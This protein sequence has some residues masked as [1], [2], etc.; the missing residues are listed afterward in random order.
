MKT[1]NKMKFL[2]ESIQ[3]YTGKKVYIVKETNE[4][5]QRCEHAYDPKIP[6]CIEKSDLESIA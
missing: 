5:A 3:L 4:E 2:S 1:D 6:F